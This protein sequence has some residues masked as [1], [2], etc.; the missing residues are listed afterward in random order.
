LL[1]CGTSNR[2]PVPSPEAN[3]EGAPSCSRV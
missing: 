1:S 2:R 3:V